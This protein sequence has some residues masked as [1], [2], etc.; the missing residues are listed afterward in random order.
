[1]IRRTQ[2]FI[3]RVNRPLGVFT[4]HDVIL[5]ALQS[6]V[7]RNGPARL[8]D[9]TTKQNISEFGFFV[10]SKTCIPSGNPVPAVK[11]TLLIRPYK[12]E[13]ILFALGCGQGL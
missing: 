7:V 4:R 3:V 13:P 8:P 11:N 1:M 9:C 6:D 2:F 10:G 12:L 5:D